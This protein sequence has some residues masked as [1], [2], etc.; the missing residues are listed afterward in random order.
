MCV[1]VHA[2]HVLVRI[3]VQGDKIVVLNMPWGQYSTVRDQIKSLDAL[4]A[5]QATLDTAQFI[6]LHPETCMPGYYD[7]CDDR[8]SDMLNTTGYNEY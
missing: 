8:Y 3:V 4:T 1:T 2:A 5:L 6:L 7:E